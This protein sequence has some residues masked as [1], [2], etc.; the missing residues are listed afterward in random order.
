MIVYN[1]NYMWKDKQ[2]EERYKNDPNF[3]KQKSKINHDRW[4][5]IKKDPILL[6][7]HRKQ[8]ADWRR[9]NRKNNP[10]FKNKENSNQRQYT[11]NRRIRVIKKLGS[12]CVCCGENRIE[13]LSANHKKNDGAQHRRE[14]GSGATYN[15]IQS[16]LEEAKNILELMCMNCN[17]S[18]G[19]FGY[20]PHK[21]K[22]K[23]I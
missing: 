2:K 6:A 11:M 16:H 7:A 14:I 23:F 4:E 21:T 15:W 8:K 1:I 10:E 12:I 3:K 19:F 20:C 9:N 22:S 5:R 18:I 17:S 13:F